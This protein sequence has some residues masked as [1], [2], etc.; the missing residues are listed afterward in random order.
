MTLVTVNIWIYAICYTLISMVRLGGSTLKKIYSILL[1]SFIF[2]IFNSPETSA[3]QKTEVKVITSP[4]KLI[5]N[6]EPEQFVTLNKN[7]IVLV[8]EEV[9]RIVKVT[10]K[11]Y[12]GYLSSQ[13]VKKITPTIQII[14]PKEGVVVRKSN[15]PKAEIV[16]KIHSNLIVNVYGTAAGGWSFVNYG[17]IYGYVPT[18]ALKTPKAKKMIVNHKDGVIVRNIA[19]FTG[20]KIGSIPNKTTLSLYTQTKEWSYVETGTIKGYVASNRLK[21]FLV[22][23]NQKYNKG[24]SGTPKKRIALT[25]DDGPHKTV[26]PQILKLLKKYDAKATFFIVGNRVKAN[27]SVLKAIYKDGH[28]IGNHTWDH[29]KLTSLSIRNV[30]S[31]FTRTNDIVYSTIGAYPTVF[32]PPYGSI[33][34]T[35]QAQINKPIILWS[36]DTLD[37]KHRNAQKTLQYVKAHASDGSIILLHD[38]HQTTAD[39]LESILQYLTKEGYELVTVTEILL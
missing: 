7:D 37:W 15:S 19:S 4:V 13:Y 25:F 30:T 38:I 5:V 36:I 1:A 10:Y 20:T 23:G 35:V 12:T 29:S 2:L 26:T 18:S 24:V 17:D 28:E 34:K 11:S 22:T 16:G 33:N 8:H 39:S 14:N 32:R 9:N 31:Q 3:T 21:D 27:S 6:N